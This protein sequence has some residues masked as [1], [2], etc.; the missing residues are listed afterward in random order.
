MAAACG[1]VRNTP[2]MSRT[3]S[4][5]ILYL[6]PLCCYLS[7]ADFTARLPSTD[8]NPLPL[9]GL[10]WP[11][12][13]GPPAPLTASRSGDP[14]YH[15]Q[16]R[17]RNHQT[18]VPLPC[19]PHLEYSAQLWDPHIQRDITNLKLYRSSLLIESN[20]P[21]LG[22]RLRRSTQYC[23]CSKSQWQ[24]TPPQTS[25]SSSG[26]N[27]RVAGSS[28]LTPSVVHSHEPTIPTTHLCLVALELGTH[29]TRWESCW[30]PSLF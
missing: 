1:S 22:F 11:R 27:L 4:A 5:N 7:F 19:P 6:R 24:K 15:P 30:Q 13:G 28:E 20:H 29:W 16:P 25:T 26:F 3:K 9:P 17:P 12:S 10:A 18:A 23:W 21:Q 14:P 2:H 8:H